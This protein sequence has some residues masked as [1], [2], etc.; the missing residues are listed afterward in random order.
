MRRLYDELKRAQHLR[1]SGRMQLGLFL[2]K[3]GLSLNESLKFWEYHF[4]PKIGAEKFQR[5]YAYS[6]R[7]N[8]GKEGK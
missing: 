3:K 4:S 6:I 2:K 7:H 5:Q 8:Y 1:H